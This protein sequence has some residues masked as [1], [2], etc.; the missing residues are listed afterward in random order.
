MLSK[1]DSTYLEL[2]ERIIL[3]D[4]LPG[5]QMTADDIV[6]QTGVSLSMARHLLVS[7]GVGGYLTK[8]GRAYVVSTFTRAQVEEWR[9]ALGAIVEIGAVRL[10]L[11][12]GARLQ[13]VAECLDRDVRSHAV[14]DE[15]FFLGAMSF[16]TIILGGSQSAL[17]ELVEQFVP[18]AFF[19]LLWLSDIYAERTGFLVEAAE[20]Y[21]VAARS[22]DLDGVREASRFFFDS[23]APALHKLIE[24]MERKAYPRDGKHH[25][26]Q[27]I[28][29]QIS[30]MPTY[31]GSTK[32]VRPLLGPLSDT[33]AA[34]HPL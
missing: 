14:E 23:T 9:L 3:G 7:L 24:Q 21:L 34:A 1:I 28:E 27:A 17:S 32:A 6:A 29:P 13:A 11:A 30:G 16:T 12:G 31:T 8:R 19:R 5:S 18:Q 15:A 20:S 26:L 2:R 10:A 25:A 22:G 33:G 4:L